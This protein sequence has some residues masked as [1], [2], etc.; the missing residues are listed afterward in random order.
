MSTEL[1][2]IINNL[3]NLPSMPPVVASALRVIEDPKSNVNQLAQILSKD[4]SLTSQILKMVNSSYYGFPNQ[5]T[6]INKAMALLGLNQ[7]KSLILSV[8]LK[9]MMLSQSGKSLWEHSV[10]CAVGCQLIAKAI[11]KGD[12]DEAF[13][14]GL[15][16]DMGK[17][18]LESCNKNLANQIHKQA[19]GGAD[20][21]KLEK[22]HFGFTHADIG[23]ALVRKWKLP[24]VIEI[25]VQYHH[26]PLASKNISL[27]GPVYV[28]N[29]LTQEN[30][31]IFEIDPQVADNL[32]FDIPDL[33]E[34]RE[35]II[36]S[37]KPVI[38][39]LK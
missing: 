6:T 28:A 15:L 38:A 21:L 34:F 26:D 23:A 4:I 24:R 18:V 3:P 19:Q 17:N 8:A 30:F 39:A 31:K 27:V 2:R 20:R 35:E 16:H 12:S 13:V 33:L 7:V 29:L 1:D 22:K 9:P 25:C 10:R 14:V 32:Y 5:I 11:G 36:E 37:T